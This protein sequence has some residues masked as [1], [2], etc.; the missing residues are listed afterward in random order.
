MLVR[1][2]AAEVRRA[3]REL[4]SFWYEAGIAESRVADV[5]ARVDRDE[6]RRAVRAALALTADPALGLHMAEHI[7]WNSFD[8]LGHLTEQSVCLREALQEV[9]TYAEIVHEHGHLVLCEHGSCATL[10]LTVPDAQ[11]VE[12]TMGAEFALL[13]LLRLMRRFV[14]EDAKPLAVCFEHQAPAHRAEYTRLFSGRERFSQAFTGFEFERT[15]LDRTPQYRSEELHS[16]LQARADFML[17]RID[18]SVETSTRVRRWLAL[19]RSDS[20]PTIRTFARGIGMSARTLRRHLRAEGIQL[21]TLVEQNMAG[22]ATRMLTDPD[23]TIQEVAYAFGFTTPSAFSR[24]F[25]RR[26]GK[27]PSAVHAPKAAAQRTR[28][29]L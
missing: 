4:A 24:A 12:S 15:W 19:N 23:N 25:K 6:Y 9:A 1:A 3:G 10:R 7:S 27:S 26:T 22:R 20:R 29:Y 16:H 5:Y 8:V 11:R 13:G 2:L 18:S 28:P 21:A 14:G 17:A